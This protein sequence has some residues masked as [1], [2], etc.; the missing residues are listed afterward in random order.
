MEWYAVIR[1]Y[2]FEH[3]LCENALVEEILF[4]RE[5]MAFGTSGFEAYHF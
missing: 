3:W 2:T 5:T 1:S 4:G